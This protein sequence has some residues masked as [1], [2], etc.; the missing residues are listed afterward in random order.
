MQIEFT[1]SFTRCLT[2]QKNLAR[3]HRLPVSENELVAR[4]QSGSV[5]AFDELML[6]H[7]AQVYALARR[8][9][10]D[11]DDAADI[12]QETFVQAWRSLKR[13][14]GDAR[15][16]T[17]L[18]R[19]AVNLCLSRKRRKDV[20][21]ERGLVEDQAGQSSESPAACMQRAETAVMFRKVLAGM[22]AHYRVLIV[23]RVIEERT[24]EEIGRMLGCSIESAR[25]RAC[26]ARNLLRERMRPFLAEEEQ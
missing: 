21:V 22:P 18:H 13:F 5:E 1:F 8:M 16:A 20:T 15:F 10:G 2:Y 17:W 4:A 11:H 26:K 12:Q 19:I 6:A 9:L 23:L 7:Q 3:S 25:R 24:Y 14:R